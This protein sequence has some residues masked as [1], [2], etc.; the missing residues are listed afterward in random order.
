MP[1][2]SLVMCF[3]V[4]TWSFPLAADSPET[5]DVALPKSLANY[6]AKPEPAF[7]WT[8]EGKQKSAAGTVYR[9]ELVSQTWHGITW[10]HALRVYEPE[11]LSH[12]HH[13]I[14]FVTGGSIGNQPRVGDIA[15]GLS[16]AQR[17]KARVAMLHQVPNQPLLGD[18]KEDD[19]IT[20]TW[21]KYLKTGDDTWPLLFPMVKSAVKAM[22]A[23]EQLAAKEWDTKLNGFVVTGASKR[24]WTSWLTA[25]ADKRILGT[26]PIVIDVLNFQ[27]Q[28]TYQRG[29]WGKYSEQ[30]IDYT[31]KGLVDEKGI[32]DSPREKAL[33]RM[34]DP[35]TYRK[36]LTMPKL[37]IVGT[38]DRYWVADA[39]SLYWDDLIG[40]KHAL[41]VPNA[42]HSLN[43][44]RDGALTT[45]AV[46]FRHVIQKKPLPAIDFQFSNG[47]GEHTLTATAKPAPVAARVWTTS[48][49]TNDLR[50]AKWTSKSVPSAATFTSRM[51]GNNVKAAATFIEFI[52]EYDD[53]PYSLT[54]AVYRRLKK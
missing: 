51:N 33:W 37:L 48:A 29:T 36:S 11:V 39:M 52:Y 6:V 4:C 3:V 47:D 9:L 18:H 35:F 8:L 54:T 7:A 28:M 10:K 42:G 27:K 20:E 53:T 15:M 43:G 22:D 12:P 40:P 23:L 30:I 1:M 46:F 49:D 14:L 19:L 32:P 5:T 45:L 38:N 26:A 2:R 50:E 24:G 44:G 41:Q 34:M 13:M 31:R 21:L 25:V 16:L 17:A